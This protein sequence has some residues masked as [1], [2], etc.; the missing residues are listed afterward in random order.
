M[1]SLAKYLCG[2]VSNRLEHSSQSLLIG[3]E[4]VPEHAVKNCAVMR[5]SELRC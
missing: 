2:V 5:N 3:S 4:I 1:L